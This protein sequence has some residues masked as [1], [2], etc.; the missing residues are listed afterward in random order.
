[1]MMGFQ[2]NRRSDEDVASDIARALVRVSVAGGV[3]QVSTPLLYP[4]GSTVDLDL[5]RF[6]EGFL[7]TDIGC[8][9][10]EA[11]LLGGERIFAGIAREIAER[12]AVRFD[13]NMLFDIEVPEDYLVPAIIAVANAA[14][15]SVETTALQMAT[16]ERVNLRSILWDR[17]ERVYR[18]GIVVRKRR[19]RGSTDE[20]EFDASVEID[21]H[22]S[23]F[24]VV[25][26]NANA[27]NSAVAKFLDIGD[28]G[29]AAPN[30]VA[31]L[32]RKE[33]TPH[34]ALLAR[35]ARVI[36]VDDADEVYRKVA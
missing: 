35:N 25:P 4:S 23:L 15:S 36:A 34:L 24:E 18:G 12:Y 9:R 11:A 16:A 1:M 22:L 26:P 20:W 33:A 6:K 19:M 13:R 31:V 10:R 7:V 17:L 8:A 29:S 5:T 2:T 28:L 30:R 32:R 27:V 3:T 14:K 21:G